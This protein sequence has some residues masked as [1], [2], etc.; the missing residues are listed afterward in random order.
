MTDEIANQ[1]MILGFDEI[2]AALQGKL[3]PK[4]AS[5]KK[6]EMKK[7]EKDESTMDAFKR[8]YIHNCNGLHFREI[9]K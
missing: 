5:P 3:D 6:R 1:T 4:T 9:K 2:K 8:W 7:N